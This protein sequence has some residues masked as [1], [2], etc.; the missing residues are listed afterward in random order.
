V[1]AVVCKLPVVNDHRHWHRSS[2]L[3]ECKVICVRW[4]A[5]V[6]ICCDQDIVMVVLSLFIVSRI[7]ID[8]LF[9]LNPSFFATIID[10]R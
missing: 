6:N 1:E 9:S 4:A 5:I 3:I 8:A 10:V 2:I 7:I